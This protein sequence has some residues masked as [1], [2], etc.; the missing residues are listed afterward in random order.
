[1]HNKGYMITFM[2][3]AA[4]L[5]IGILFLFQGFLGTIH[6]VEASEEAQPIQFVSE[7]QTTIT[8]KE[9]P[10]YYNGQERKVAYLT[11][12]D[13]PGKPTAELLDMLKEHDAKATFFVVGPRVKQHPE[14]VERQLKEGHYTGMHS[15]THQYG[16]LYKQGQFVEEMKENQQIITDVIKTE[17]KLVRPPYGSMPG[18]TEEL[19]NKVV[20][21]DLKVWDWTIDSLDWKYNKA[22]VD[23]GAAKI[24]EHVVANATKPVEVILLHDIHEQSV[25]A[26]PAIIE[27]LAA[28]GY[29]FESYSE[30]AHFPVNFWKDDRL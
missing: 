20:E 24:A 10:K 2:K 27:G 1:M 23:V 22:P 4:I 9:T 19:R 25:A 12:D 29:E 26:V 13:G 8:Q 14:L 7:M 28:K 30:N 17:P 3:R 6:I 18:L 16:K 5:C 11:F 21:N 15:M